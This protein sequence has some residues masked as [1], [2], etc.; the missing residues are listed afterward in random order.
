MINRRTIMFAALSMA[1][2]FPARGEK[3]G[4]VTLWGPPA[5]PSIILVNA[6]HNGL[7]NKIIPDV[8]FRAWK[9]P[10]EMRAG[11]ASGQMEAVILPSYVA[12]NFYNK[13]LDIRLVNI[14]TGGLMYIVTREGYIRNIE[15][16]AG[17]KIAVNFKNDM[18]DFIFR[19]VLQQNSMKPSDVDIIYTTTSQESAQ[20][21][22][23]G[24]VEATLMGEPGA[25][26]IIT[27]AK[28]KGVIL[29]RAIDI[30]SLWAASEKNRVIPQAGLAVTGPFLKRI[31]MAGL[32]TMQNAFSETVNRVITENTVAAQIA[33]PLLD[34]PADIIARSIGF[35]NLVSVRASQ[36]R[37]DLESLFSILAEDDPRIIGGQMP[38]DRFYAI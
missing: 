19:R 29:E 13:K 28:K 11:I 16:L 15:D 10:D 1:A 34:L 12:A 26:A 22:V 21:L 20:M 25:T 37:P 30:Q 38:D 36:A 9:T 35:S 24:R 8:S 27:M 23:S 3:K 2:C 4:A 18:P 14:L 32:E 31:G 17:K 6:I 5:A 7:L 33:A